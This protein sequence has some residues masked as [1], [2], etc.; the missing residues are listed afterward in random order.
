MAKEEDAKEQ[1]ALFWQEF[2]EETGRSERKGYLEAFYFGATEKL[3][4][5]L[6]RLVLIGQKKTTT[7][8]LWAYEIEGK[9]VPK[10]GDLSIVT[11]WEGVPHCVIETVAVMVLRFSD[12][13]YDLC[14]REGEDDTLESWRAGHM[15]YF[16][17]EG[18]RSGYKFSEDMTVVFEDFVV[19]YQR[20]G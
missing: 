16:E 12:M 20:G 18:K 11:D 10:A 3:A 17:E 6:L 7:S 4:N 13:T 9:A 1:L 2:L 15:R 8:S 14:R 5:E 19:V